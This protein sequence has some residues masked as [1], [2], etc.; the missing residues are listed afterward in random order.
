MKQ[1]SFATCSTH[2]KKAIAIITV[3]RKQ[4]MASWV[5]TQKGRSFVYPIVH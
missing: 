1:A 2:K 5:S 4:Y 3:Q